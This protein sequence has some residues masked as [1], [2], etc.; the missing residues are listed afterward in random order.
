MFFIGFSISVNA[1]ESFSD[2]VERFIDFD[3]YQ[4]MQF[5]TPATFQVGDREINMYFAKVYKGLKQDQVFIIGNIRN[6][7]NINNGYIHERQDFLKMREFIFDRAFGKDMN[8]IKFSDSGEA[9]FND[10]V[11]FYL[12]SYETFFQFNPFPQSIPSLQERMSI[13]Q[14]LQKGV[15]TY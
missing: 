14:F 15:S 11:M 8:H 3:T 2:N 4:T 7:S 13:K 5:A 1:T 10:E 6:N 12:G 9:Y